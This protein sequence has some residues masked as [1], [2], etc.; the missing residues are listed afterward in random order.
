[1]KTKAG[2][3]N[4]PFHPMLVVFP[5]GL[6]VFSFVCDIIYKFTNI[7]VWQQVSIYTLAGGIIGAA[8]AS[9]PGLADLFDLPKSTAQTKG[10]WHMIVNVVVLT[11]LTIVFFLKIFSQADLIA[12]ILFAIGILLLI[13]GGWLGGDLVFVHG[14]A[15]GKIDEELKEI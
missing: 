6:W 3:L 8:A 9:L 1:M 5:L 7:P 10:I 15:V 14:V 2:I 11:I 12:F 4:H 13:V